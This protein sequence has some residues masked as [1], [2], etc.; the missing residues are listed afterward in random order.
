MC[1]TGTGLVGAMIFAVMLQSGCSFMFVEGPPAKHAERAS[2]E[3]S[4]SNAAPM[5]D[6][7]SAAVNG[8]GVALAANEDRML[9]REQD[10]KVNLTWLAVSGISAIYGFRKVSQCKDA[11]RLRNE[12]YESERNPAPVSASAASGEAPAPGPVAPAASGIAP[13]RT[14]PATAPAP[15]AAPAPPA[16]APA[17]ATSGTA[18]L[19]PVAPGST[20]S[21]PTT[22]L[23]PSHSLLPAHLAVRSSPL[24]AL[25]MRPAL[26]AD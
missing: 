5:V 24:R 13:V 9:N 6:T 14:A 7:I 10:M 11:K 21:V 26:A 22:S 18:P 2:F 4:T 16:A 3:C 25:A 17:P 12:R 19:P 23:S 15:A 8:L 1:V 20:S